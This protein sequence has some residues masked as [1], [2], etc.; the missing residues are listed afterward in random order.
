ME[1][2]ISD[3]RGD[4]NDR[5]FSQRFYPKGIRRLRV[6]DKRS[7]DFRGMI[8]GGRQFVIQQIVLM[9]T[10]GLFIKLHLFC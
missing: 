3:R 10:A 8:H 4:G 5:R 6:F 2:R 7:P 1:D 9:Q